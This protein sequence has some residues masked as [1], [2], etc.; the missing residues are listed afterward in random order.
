MIKKYLVAGL[1]IWAPVGI[2][3]WV[4]TLIVRT[5]DQSLGLLPQQ[6]RP[7]TWLG[8][9]IPGAGVVFAVLLVF[10]TGVIAANF[11][12]A[13]LFAVGE[14][15]LSRI[16]I[17]RGIY[18]SVKQVSDTILSP[19]GNAFRHALLVEYPRKGVWTIAFLTGQPGSEVQHACRQ[20]PDELVSVY[21]PTTPNPTSGFF[22]V[23]RRDETVQLEM[24]VDEALRYIV[25]MGVV[26]PPSRGGSEPDG[27]H[28]EHGPPRD[29]V[30]D[31]HGSPRFPLSS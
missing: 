25:S 9:D 12:G 4:L 13:R 30:H 31:E 2:T 1:L 28:D 5:M 7:S 15:L 24:S 22:L 27:V 16:P 6:W 17:V 21:V 26:A 20:G 23:M 18:S 11:I 19:N 14:H 10:A 29:G 8:H 3:I